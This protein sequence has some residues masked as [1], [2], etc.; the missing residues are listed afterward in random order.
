VQ[1]IFRT[2]VD[3]VREDF[4]YPVSLIRLLQE[5]PDI[6]VSLGNTTQSIA[7]DSVVP[8]HRLGMAFHEHCGDRLQHSK[9]GM[10]MG[11]KQHANYGYGSFHLYCPDYFLIGQHH[12]TEHW[13]CDIAEVHGFGASKSKLC[14]FA[15]TDQMV[16]ANSRDMINEITHKKLIDNL[17]HK[18]IGI[19]HSP[20]RDFFCR[21]SWDG[22]LFLMNSDG[23]HHFAAAKYIAARLPELVEIRGTLHTYSLNGV[24]IASLRRDYDMFIICDDPSI[25]GRFHEAMKAFKV[26]WLWSPMP[27]AFGDIKVIFLPKTQRRSMRVADLLRGAGVAD[28]GA[29]LARLADV[30]D[31]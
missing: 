30:K 31:Q 1:S 13:V 15:S 4:G 14:E 24:A 11:W 10:L 23:S 28:L 16:E 12:I 27:L 26:T 21:Y 17:N 19:I 8:W 22:R 9:P 3:G 20:G 29:L 6:R 25:S 2:I 7:A 5:R 18:D